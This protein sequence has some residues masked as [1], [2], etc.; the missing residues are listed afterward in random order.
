M[1]QIKTLVPHFVEVR[2]QQNFTEFGYPADILPTSRTR[3]GQQITGQL[4]KT[5]FQSRWDCCS[6]AI[7]H[8]LHKAAKKLGAEVVL[9][10]QRNADKLKAPIKSGFV[11]DGIRIEFPIAD[12]TDAEVFAFLEKENIQLP[13]SYKEGMTSGLDCW[14][15]TAYLHERGRIDYLKRHHPE[16]FAEIKPVLEELHSAV[17]EETEILRKTIHLEHHE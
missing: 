13:R 3:V 8:P 16:K 5:R 15:C 14:N 2:S 7:W 4:D 9:R 12:W 10:G 17:T 1:A 6:Y 11:V